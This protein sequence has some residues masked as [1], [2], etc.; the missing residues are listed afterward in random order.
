MLPLNGKSGGGEAT[1][2]DIKK[3]IW[4]FV[5]SLQG[6]IDETHS[7]QVHVIP[8]C[9]SSDSDKEQECDK[10]VKGRD[11][12]GSRLLLPTVTGVLGRHLL[13]MFHAAF[14]ALGL[15]LFQMKIHPSQRPIGHRYCHCGRITTI[16]F[17][18]CC[19]P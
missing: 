19:P 6:I 9:H 15:S 12:L 2:A 11:F 14:F 13:E 4:I 16:F 5:K 18:G 7:M 1:E 8:P 10:N 3:A 17:I